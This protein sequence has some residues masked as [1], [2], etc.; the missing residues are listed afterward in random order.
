V[1][2]NIGDPYTGLVVKLKRN[3]TGQFVG[4]PIPAL[5]DVDGYYSILYKHTGPQAQYTVMYWFPTQ[6]LMVD[7]PVAQQ[8]VITMQPNKF[9]NVS[10]TNLPID[11]TP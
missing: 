7:P 8:A 6:N 11:P 1:A 2:P 9:Y 4:T 10:F 5:S 3:S